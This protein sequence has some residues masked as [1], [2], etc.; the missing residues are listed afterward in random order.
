MADA[1]A[2]YQPPSLRF[3]HSIT[4]K[5]TDNNYAF[6]KRQFEAL[7]TVSSS[8]DLSQAPKR[9]QLK[10]SRSLASMASMRLLRIQTTNSGFRQTKSFSPGFSVLLLKRSKLS[11]FTAQLHMRS[12]QPW[13]V[14]STGPLTHASLNSSTSSKLSPKTARP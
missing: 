6:W 5:L 10:P 2:L 9:N 8:L 1:I 3:V 11:S 7:S 4:V 13:T 14:T 12:G